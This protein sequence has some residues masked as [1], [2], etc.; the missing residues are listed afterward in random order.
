MFIGVDDLLRL[1]REGKKVSYVCE[2]SQS[3]NRS[4]SVDERSSS[5][6]GLFERLC[7]RKYRFLH[8]SCAPRGNNTVCC[9]NIIFKGCVVRWAIGQLESFSISNNY[10]TVLSSRFPLDPV[11]SVTHIF[12]F[13][14]KNKSHDILMTFS[15]VM[16]FS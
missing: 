8:F 4:T 15:N 6:P 1:L 10:S 3:N 12:V 14:R 13:W 16:T 9:G 5:S 7:A 2:A 11:D